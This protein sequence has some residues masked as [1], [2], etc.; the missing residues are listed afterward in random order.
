MNQQKET[1]S[2]SPDENPCQEISDRAVLAKKPIVSV[3]MSTY[4]HEPYIAQAI[5]GVVMQ[6]TEYPFELIIG[7]DCST[8]R[9]REIAFEYQKKYP[10]IIR[11][12]AWDKNVGMRKNGQQVR[13]ACRGKYVAWC[14]G[15]D[16]W[17]DPRKL[18][19]QVDY[20]AANPEVVLVAHR[21]HKVDLN[22]NIMT[23]FPSPQP[24]YLRPK[25]I[26]IKGGGFF[27]TNSMM[28]KKSL[29]QD[30][31]DWCCWFPVGDVAVINLAIHRGKVGFINEIMSDHRVGVPGS[32]TTRNNN[33]KKI[34]T[35][36]WNVDRAYRR[37]MRQE[38]RYT[39][40]YHKKRLILH[41]KMVIVC[42]R[43]V[44]KFVLR[45]FLR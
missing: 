45:P 3:R 23:T 19:K 10:D 26:I 16:Y 38:K 34:I 18:Q 15:D 21:A 28:L 41:W 36:L 7:E 11:V 9:T 8:D 40:W 5:E 22:S 4:N 31:P 43:R 20:F 29:L 6:E 30:M 14:E 12:I 2:F 32:W 37:L 44:A 27:A 13:I 1:S 24:K 42:I 25:D 35:H 39:F 17:T 33:V